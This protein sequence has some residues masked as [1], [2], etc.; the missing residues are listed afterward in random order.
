MN[1]KRIIRS[2]NLVPHM[3]FPYSTKGP[4]AYLLEGAEVWLQAGDPDSIP[5]WS[6][7]T[8]LV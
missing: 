2:P 4:L 6:E 7:F 8:G 1:S 3:D 5:R